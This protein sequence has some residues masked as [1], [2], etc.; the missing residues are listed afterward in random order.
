MKIFTHFRH[1]S[2]TIKSRFACRLTG[3]FWQ[4]N[5]PKESGELGVQIWVVMKCIP[6]CLLMLVL[7]ARSVS[8]SVTQDSIWPRTDCYV[9]PYLFSLVASW[10]RKGRWAGQV[11][12]AGAAVCFE[13][14]K[15]EA[16]KG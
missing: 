2:G 12:R 8:V 15:V 11:G 10:N 9:I 1:V 6:T 7:R 5:G 3:L 13:H 16:E 4:G 14:R